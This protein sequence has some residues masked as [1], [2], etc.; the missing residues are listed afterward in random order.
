[1]PTTKLIIHRSSFF[2][3]LTLLILIEM[4]ILSCNSSLPTIPK[5]GD[6]TVRQLKILFIGSSY[7]NYN[8]LPSLFLNMNEAAEKNIFVDRRTVNGKGLDYHARDGFTEKKINQE[9]WDYVI[10]QGSCTNAAYPDSH[11]YFIPPFVEHPLKSSLQLLKQKILASNK[12]AKIIYCMPWAFEDGLTWIEGQTDTYEDM[13]KKIFINTIPLA[14]ELDIMIAPVGWA[15]YQILKNCN[16]VH[17]L[18]AA[19]WNHPSLRGS[20][21]TTCVIFTTIY[22]ENSEGLPYF[23]GLP[24]DEARFFQ[25]VASHTVI[26]NLMLWNLQ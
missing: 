15:W 4:I 9:A 1:M 13:Q 11:Q 10:L 22:Q 7:F 5:A 24:A 8:D 19:D 12:N 23:G 16:T 17:Y 25:I 6:S 3:S 21:L 14:R 18:H 20:Y 26:D 2:S